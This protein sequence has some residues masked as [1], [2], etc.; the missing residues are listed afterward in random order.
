M[1]A[2]PCPPHW[3]VFATVIVAAAAVPED[4]V[5]RAVA[6]WTVVPR[7]R[8]DDGTV[9]IEVRPAGV[10]FGIAPVGSGPLVG[11]VVFVVGPVAVVQQT[12]VVVEEKNRSS[13]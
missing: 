1:A 7:W 13:L 6:V 9:A 12:W 11:I 4:P 5:R 2:L 10:F 8:F 3:I